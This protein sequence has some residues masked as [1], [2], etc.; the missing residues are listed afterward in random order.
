VRFSAVEETYVIEV[1]EASP[2]PPDN[3]WVILG[4]VEC[5]RDGHVGTDR[6]G[7]QHARECR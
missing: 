4:G 5:D 7:R 2:H 3:L 1:F 6:S